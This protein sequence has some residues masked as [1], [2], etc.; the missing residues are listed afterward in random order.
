MTTRPPWLPK[1]VFVVFGV[2]VLAIGMAFVWSAVAG[3]RA[4]TALEH[5]RTDLNK[6]KANPP[7]REELLR[8]LRLD[9]AKAAVA[10]DQMHQLGPAVVSHLPFIGRSIVAEQTIADAA[11]AVLSSGSAAAA[12]TDGLSTGGTGVNLAELAALHTILVDGAA[13]TSGP[14]SRLAKLN[15]GL[16]PSPVR[17]A[18]HQAQSELGGISTSFAHVGALTDAVGDLLGANGPRTIYIGL[19]NNAELRGTGGLISTFTLAHA[20]NGHLTI[21]PF[22]DSQGVAKRAENA[23]RVPAPPDYVAH[24]GGY[25]ANTTLWL[26]ATMDPDIPASAS[27]ISSLSRVSFGTK[28]DAVLLLDVAGMSKIVSAHRPAAPERRRCR[29]AATS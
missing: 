22:R 2:L 28:A 10:R 19:E 24:Y 12:A 25:L 8:R 14:L 27:V 29:S 3:L 11:S 4:K 23:V 5:V 6:V 9:S 16:T 21:Q 7:E 17:K 1:A 13:K 18:V 15:T 20:A 26:N